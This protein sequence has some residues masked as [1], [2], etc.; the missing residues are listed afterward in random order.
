MEPEPSTL[1]LSTLVPTTTIYLAILHP[2][3]SGLSLRSCSEASVGASRPIVNQLTI[4]ARFRRR[5]NL[6]WAISQTLYPSRLLSFSINPS[7]CPTSPKRRV[8]GQFKT[9][10]KE[11]NLEPRSETKRHRGAAGQRRDSSQK[12]TAGRQG[13]RVAHDQRPVKSGTAIER[14]CRHSSKSRHPR[15]AYIG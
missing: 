11:I 1:T 15:C 9:F 2:F 6:F 3:V 14:G 13:N 12:A 4:Q 7:L 10:R 5:T 8:L